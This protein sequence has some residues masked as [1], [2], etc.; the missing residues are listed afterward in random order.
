MFG[1]GAGPSTNTLGSLWQMAFGGGTKDALKR[2]Q[3]KGVEGNLK[4]LA[5][6]ERSGFSD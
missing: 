4:V 3:A 5:S 1:G 2:V 6:P